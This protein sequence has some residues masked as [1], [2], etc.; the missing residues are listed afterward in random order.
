MLYVPMTNM[1]MMLKDSILRAIEA[2]HKAFEILQE[3]AKARQDGLL[4]VYPQMAEFLSLS[5]SNPKFTVVGGHSGFVGISEIFV[6][7][8]GTRPRGCGQKKNPVYVMRSNGSISS[9]K[10]WTKTCGS[11]RGV[12]S[13]QH[14][15]CLDCLRE[16]GRIW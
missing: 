12:D 3:R 1:P 16:N 8:I 13:G 5:P 2:N 15:F 6:E 10:P 14:F 7:F 4:E 11:E 9:A